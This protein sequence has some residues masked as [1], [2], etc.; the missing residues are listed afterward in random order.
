MAATAPVFATLKAE[1]DVR[2]AG[3]RAAFADACSTG[4]PKLDEVLCGGFVRGTIA[5]LEGGPSSGRTAVLAS[6]LARATQSGLAAVI[7]DSTLYPPALEHAGVCLDR[8][9]VVR[10]EAPLQAA[11]AADILLRAR[12]FAVVA[13]TALAEKH[14]VLRAAIWS[15]L[16][17]L[18]HKA[19]SVLLV[20]NAQADRELAPF[21]TT[22]LRCAI[23]RVVW[24]D[25][26]AR[27]HELAGY[28]IAA[29][30]IKHRRTLPGARATL[31][32]QT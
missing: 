4:Q 8:L 27:L 19:G 28:E 32:A 2:G 12:A 20:L 1:L 25:A 13:V 11:R 14:D 23:D 29:G 22:R 31:Q 6:V 5:T 7:D 15:R 17:G 24:S 30:V 18:A 26:P 3:L 16:A 9:L 10:L 21:A